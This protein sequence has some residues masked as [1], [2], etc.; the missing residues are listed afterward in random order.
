MRFLHRS[1]VPQNLSADYADQTAVETYLLQ[2]YALVIQ[3][4]R[5]ICH[6]LTAEQVNALTGSTNGRRQI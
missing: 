6:E 2:Q 4:G 1:A 3:H 5:F